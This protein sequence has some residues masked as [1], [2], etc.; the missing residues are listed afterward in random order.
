MI[1]DCGKLWPSF[2]LLGSDA[3]DDPSVSYTAAVVEA[4]DSG[5]EQVPAESSDMVAQQHVALVTQED[6]SQQQVTRCS[7]IMSS[8]RRT[9]VMTYHVKVNSDLLTVFM[10]VYM[11]PCCNSGYAHDF[12]NVNQ[13]FCLSIWLNYTSQYFYCDRIDT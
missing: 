6:G 7:D 8:K 4:D 1:L 2:S 13:Q 3:I 9:E 12:K 5:S 10:C 11:G